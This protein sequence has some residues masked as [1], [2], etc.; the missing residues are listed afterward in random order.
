MGLTT[1][2]VY[3]ALLPVIQ[4][5][6]TGIVHDISLYFHAIGLAWTL[7]VGFSQGQMYN[8]R[9]V[10]FNLEIPP[11]TLWF[12]MGL[13][14]DDTIHFSDACERL[15]VAVLEQMRL[16]RSTHVLGKPSPLSFRRSLKK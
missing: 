2:L 3:V 13:W 16:K 10:T 12:N 7:L 14:S 8:L 9:H 11:K 1:V 15:V 6:T 4:L 5:G